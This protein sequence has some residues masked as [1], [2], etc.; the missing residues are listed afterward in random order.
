[1]NWLQ[2]KIKRNALKQQKEYIK[3]VEQAKKNGLMNPKV[4]DNLLKSL[5]AAKD[6]VNDEKDTK[7]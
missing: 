2:K 5:K 6:G 1:M 7:E 3:L 4:A